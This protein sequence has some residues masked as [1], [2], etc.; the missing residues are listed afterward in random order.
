MHFLNKILMCFFVLFLCFTAKSNAASDKFTNFLQINEVVD[1]NIMLKEFSDEKFD[2]YL[3]NI[4]NNDFPEYESAIRNLFIVYRHDISELNTCIKNSS[5]LEKKFNNKWIEELNSKFG[6][7]YVAKKYNSISQLIYNINNKHNTEFCIKNEK[8]V[9]YSEI[10]Y[11]KIVKDFCEYYIGFY[12]SLNKNGK[13]RYNTKKNN[14]N[15]MLDS[16]IFPIQEL[17]HRKNIDPFLNLR[18]KVE[19][20]KEVFEFI[21]NHPQFSK[22]FK[23]VSAI[24]N[25]KISI[26]KD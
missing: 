4:T 16:V 25:L 5:E 26:N 13:K 24:E 21:V 20:K 3:K 22:P 10:Q 1:L 11:I 17:L 12:N 7:K 14:A 8:D 23:L 2:T 9:L 18:N 15:K 6:E 19:I